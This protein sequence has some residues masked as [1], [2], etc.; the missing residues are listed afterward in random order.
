M[1][2]RGGPDGDG[3][4]RHGGPRLDSGPP[5]ARHA[6][7]V[8]CTEPVTGGLLAK[9]DGRKEDIQQNSGSKLVFS[10]K[11]DYFPDSQWRVLAIYCDEMQ[12]IMS[13]LGMI[14]DYTVDVAQDESHPDQRRELLGKEEGEY[15]FRLCITAQMAGQL[16]GTRGE[17]VKKMREETGAKVFIDNDSVMGHR[18]VRVIGAPDKILRCLETINEYVQADAGNADF[19]EFASLV[20]FGEASGQHDAGGGGGRGYAAPVGGGGGGAG[21]AAS[22]RCDGPPPQ[23][24]RR[25]DRLCEGVLRLSEDI[26]RFPPGAADMAYSMQSHL[27]ADKVGAVVGRGGEIVKA[28]ER[29]TG[30]KVTIDSEV[31]DGFRVMTVEGPLMQMYEAHAR[32]MQHLQVAISSQRYDAHQRAAPQMDAS[33]LSAKISELQRQLDDIKSRGGR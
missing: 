32:L 13:A 21:A 10:N 4:R 9:K 29:E 3:D 14:L 23:Q 1:K 5:R 16:I 8:L 19:A 7:K 2:R 15:I 24:R 33:G 20:N 12:G 22:S 11:G 6:F 30:A 28:V 17:T 18:L 27:P 25:Q 31:I 26:G